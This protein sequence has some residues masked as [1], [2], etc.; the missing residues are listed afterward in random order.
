LDLWNWSDETPCYSVYSHLQ[1]FGLPL[2]ALI[3]LMFLLC[4]VLCLCV[5]FQFFWVFFVYCLIVYVW[6]RVCVC[7]FVFVRE[8]LCLDVF[9][10]HVS[11]TDSFVVMVSIWNKLEN[12]LIVF[13]ITFCHPFVFDLISMSLYFQHTLNIYRYVS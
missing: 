11:K 9:F 2:L 3:V 5:C 8:C 13:Q 6:N 10:V 12:I 1:N 7:V 4:F